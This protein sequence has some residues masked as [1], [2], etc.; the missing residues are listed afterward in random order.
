NDETLCPCNGKDTDGP[1]MLEAT[2]WWRTR[3][4]S[5]VKIGLPSAIPMGRVVIPVPVRWKGTCH[6]LLR[7]GL[8]CKRTLPT[9][10]AKR[11]RVCLLSFHRSSGKAGN[12]S[13]EVFSLCCHQVCVHGCHQPR[14][15]ARSA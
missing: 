1:S 10:G 15:V 3:S 7:R 5:T 4:R 13:I 2:S 14:R 9:I 6:Q 11:C 8:W 12:S